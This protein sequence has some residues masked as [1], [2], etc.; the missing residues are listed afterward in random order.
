MTGVKAALLAVCI[1]CCLS[2]AFA[3]LAPSGGYGKAVRFS[4]SL[5]V[6]IAI[7]LAI[8]S[9]RNVELPDC[10][11]EMKAY[12]TDLSDTVRQK[13]KDNITA[14][15]KVQVEEV[16]RQFEIAECEVKVQMHIS[17]SGSISL[18]QVDVGIPSGYIGHRQLI[19]DLLDSR[20]GTY[21][22]VY[23]MEE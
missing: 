8:G 22:D 9:V 7:A 15:I 13:L 2:G 16:M 11:G 19:K 10:S 23:V 6:L 4:V 17:D 18:S 20:L 3:L 5:L 14:G 12:Q 1:I 21:T